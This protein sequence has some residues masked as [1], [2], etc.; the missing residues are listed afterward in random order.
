MK[1][2]KCKTKGCHSEKLW[3]TKTETTGSMVALTDGSDEFQFEGKEQVDSI[4]YE[5]LSCANGHP[6]MI[7]NEPVL[8][9]E[10]YKKWLELFGD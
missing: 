7:D 4:E 1:K 10:T 8:D 5:K 6:L 9:E 2:F 3:L